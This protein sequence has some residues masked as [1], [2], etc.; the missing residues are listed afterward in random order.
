MAHS[1][2][3]FRTARDTGDRLTEQPRLVFQRGVEPALPS[4]LVDAT[5]RYQE[6]EGFGGAFTEAAAVALHRM[7]S[8]RQAE[9]LKHDRRLVAPKFRKCRLTIVSGNDLIVF[10]GPAELVLN[11]EIILDN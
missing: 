6:I 3:L 8:E 7:S 2:Q 5:N 10:E 9:I 11:A 4:I 1:I